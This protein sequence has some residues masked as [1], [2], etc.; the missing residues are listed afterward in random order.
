MTR[1]Q[2]GRSGL[3]YAEGII[4]DRTSPGRVCS[5]FPRDPG[6]EALD[7]DALEALYGDERARC[8]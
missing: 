2:I 6:A 5:S 8:R 1:G 3:D 4:F 7:D